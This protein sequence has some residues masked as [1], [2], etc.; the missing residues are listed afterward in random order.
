MAKA[1]MLPG[2]GCPACGGTGLTMGPGGEVLTCTV[3]GQTFED[4]SFY[5]RGE[6]A[7]EPQVAIVNYY[8][9]M[10]TLRA[11]A[12][13]AVSAIFAII[14]GAL[15]LFA[16]ES[17][18]VAANIIAGAFLVLAAGIAGFTRLKAS[19]PG[20]KIDTDQR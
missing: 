2:R 6:E 7:M 11:I 3:C 19:A 12:A 4:R 8:H 20:I 16:P 14:A 9:K 17:R 15:I 13:Y 10:A 18:V 1:P 5:A